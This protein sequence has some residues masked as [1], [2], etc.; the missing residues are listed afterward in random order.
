MYDKPSDY[1]PYLQPLARLIERMGKR[2]AEADKELREIRQLSKETDEQLKE[3][4]Q[5]SK[6]TDEQIKRLSEQ[7]G[8]TD[9]RFGSLAEAM[10]LGDAMELLNSHPQLDIHSVSHNTEGKYEGKQYEIDAFAFGDDC[11]IVMEAKATLSSGDVSNFIHKSVN[12]KNFFDIYQ[13]HR[14]KKLYGAVAYLKM[15]GKAKELANKNGLLIIKSSYTNKVIDNPQVKLKDYAP[16][17][18]RTQR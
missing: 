3:I 9:R 7:I 15:T 13:H 11:V 4:S 17:Q 16:K 2:Q 1:P 12:L 8:A 10:T 6:K 14:G 5:L 18:T